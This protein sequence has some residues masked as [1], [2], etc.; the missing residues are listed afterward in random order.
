MGSHQ[1]TVRR[2][3]LTLIAVCCS[4]L[5]LGADTDSGKARIALFEPA[6]QKVEANA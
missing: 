1:L 4:L 6:G 5:L 3:T 2:L